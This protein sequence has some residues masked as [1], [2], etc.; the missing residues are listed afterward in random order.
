MMETKEDYEKETGKLFYVIADYL[1]Y[2]DD[3][4]EAMDYVQFYNAFT[5]SEIT[6]DEFDEFVK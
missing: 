1:I 6:E 3:E 5:G 2:A 4:V